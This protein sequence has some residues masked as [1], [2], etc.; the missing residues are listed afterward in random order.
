MFFAEFTDR[1]CISFKFIYIDFQ[2]CFRRNVT[3]IRLGNTDLKFR[4]KFRCKINFRFTLIF[5]VLKSR[6]V[7][8]P[9]LLKKKI[10]II[11]IIFGD[12][13]AGS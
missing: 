13:F 5:V 9:Y 2:V 8:Q 12:Y 10:C 3:E 7:K 11:A 4:L 1:S 6:F